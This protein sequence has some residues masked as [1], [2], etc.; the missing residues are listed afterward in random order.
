MKQLCLSVVCLVGGSSSR[1]SSSGRGDALVPICMQH[2][3]S[4]VLLWPGSAG[5]LFKYAYEV[6]AHA[7]GPLGKLS[8]GR[9]PFGTGCSVHQLALSTCGSW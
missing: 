5:R 7:Q 2:L 3:C 1:S 9:C 8:W 6:E 4:W